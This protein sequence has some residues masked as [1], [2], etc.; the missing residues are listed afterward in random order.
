MARYWKN[1]LAKKQKERKDNKK[2]KKSENK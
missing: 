1:E 2:V